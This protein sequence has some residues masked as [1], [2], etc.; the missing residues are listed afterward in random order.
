M[1]DSSASQPAPHT[2]IQSWGALC[3]K[4]DDQMNVPE[5]VY[6][7]SNGEEKKSTDRT[8]NGVYG[9]TGGAERYLANEEGSIILDGNNRPITVRY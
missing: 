8:S 2:L 3:H 5:V 7:F 1:A 9:A 6:R 4:L